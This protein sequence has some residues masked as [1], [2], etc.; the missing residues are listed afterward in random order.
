MNCEEYVADIFNRRD[1]LTLKEMI[2]L[3]K[4]KLYYVDER[5]FET[6]EQL[7]KAL[8]PHTFYGIVAE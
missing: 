2:K 1:S 4:E 5:A 3:L 8:I 7:I 6:K